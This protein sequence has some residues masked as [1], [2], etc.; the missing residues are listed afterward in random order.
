MDEDHGY[1]LLLLGRAPQR[2]HNENKELPRNFILF[3]CFVYLLFLFFLSF[4]FLFSL[5]IFFASLCGGDAPI[6]PLRSATGCTLNSKLMFLVFKVDY[7]V[8]RVCH[9]IESHVSSFACVV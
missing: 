8:V 9:H 3:T 2:A 6:A 7:Y 1:Y 4:L 5:F